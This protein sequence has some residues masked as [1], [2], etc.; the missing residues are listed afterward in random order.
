VT[1][2]TRAPEVS[3]AIAELE[4]AFDDRVTVEAEEASGVIVRISGV[5]LSARWSPR[6]GELWLLIPFHY[7]DAAIYPYYITGATPTGGLIGGLQSVHWRGMAA[8]QVSLR[9]TA[10]DPKV[11]TAL[12]SVLQTQ[13]WLRSR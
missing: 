6:V 3:T 10:W 9:H 7:P 4:A 1:T 13:A 12:G 11:D 8:V 5:E 2:V